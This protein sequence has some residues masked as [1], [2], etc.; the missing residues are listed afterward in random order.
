MVKN[1]SAGTVRTHRAAPTSSWRER[2]PTTVIVIAMAVFAVMFWSAGFPNWQAH[3][4]AHD[5]A[6]PVWPAY[7]WYFIADITDSL[8]GAMVGA[9]AGVQATKHFRERD[10]H[11]SKE[12]K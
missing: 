6:A 10:N 2:K 9:L 7:M 5:A 4:Q 11:P 3:Q 1:A 12:D 8:V